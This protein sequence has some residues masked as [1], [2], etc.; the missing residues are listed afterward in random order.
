MPSRLAMKGVGPFVQAVRGFKR[1]AEG[2]SGQEW[3][4]G[5]VVGYGQYHEYGTSRFPARPHWRPATFVLSQ[6]I[7]SGSLPG[8]RRRRSSDVVVRDGKR[9]WELWW[10]PEKASGGAMAAAYKRE[11]KRQI[12][13][14]GVF[15]TGNYHG[16][17]A[18]GRTEGEM[19]ARSKAMV[20]NPSSAVV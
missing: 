7:P 3:S 9:E 1:A 16:S 5:T 18:H 13:A 15:D 14:K 4:V 10:E 6:G 12:K 11:V 2:D 19:V 17:I 20:K 8:A